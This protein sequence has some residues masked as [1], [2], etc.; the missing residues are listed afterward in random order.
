LRGADC[1]PSLSATARRVRSCRPAPVY[2][3]IQSVVTHITS[4]VRSRPRMNPARQTRKISRIL[5]ARYRHAWLRSQSRVGG[6]VGRGGGGRRA[7]EA[8]VAGLHARGRRT[9]TRAPWLH[10][11]DSREAVAITGRLRVGE[12][13]SHAICEPNRLAGQCSRAPAAPV[14]NCDKMHKQS[15]QLWHTDS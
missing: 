1:Y 10:S 3:K 11:R 13:R 14:I 2:C 4:L 8:M 9:A 5:R 15:Q 7:G 12:W 6:C